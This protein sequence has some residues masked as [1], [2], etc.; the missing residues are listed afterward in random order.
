MSS[1]DEGDLASLSAEFPG[2]HVWRGRDRRWRWDGWHATRRE[3]P[4]RAEALA[5][6]LARLSAPAPA[7]LRGLL[8]QQQ[9]LAEG[10]RCAA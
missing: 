9:A 8:G 3:V 5:G 10:L 1:T 2:W 7:E 6:V 4:A